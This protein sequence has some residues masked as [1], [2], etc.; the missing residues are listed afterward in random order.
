MRTRL[1]TGPV[2]FVV[3]IYPKVFKPKDHAHIEQDEVNTV[4]RSSTCEAADAGAE[5]QRSAEMNK[6][7]GGTTNG[8]MM[9]TS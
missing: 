3:K 9:K 7:C 2:Q 8:S 5:E 1:L 6:L 4:L